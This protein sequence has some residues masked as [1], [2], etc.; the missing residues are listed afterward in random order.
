ME[1]KDSQ[2]GNSEDFCTDYL[3]RKRVVIQETGA[4]KYSCTQLKQII[5]SICEQKMKITMF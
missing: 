4:C 3:P 2:Y 1:K 5:E